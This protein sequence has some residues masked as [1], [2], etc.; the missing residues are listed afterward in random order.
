MNKAGKGRGV[1]VLCGCV[2]GSCTF[3]IDWQGKASLREEDLSKD[4][5]EESVNGENDSRGRQSKQ[6]GSEAG[7]CSAH[8]RNIEKACVAGVE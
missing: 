7:T 1:G 4:L 6:K 8:V 2:R 5:K 3:Q